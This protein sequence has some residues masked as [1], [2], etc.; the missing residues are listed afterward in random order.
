[1]FYLMTMQNTNILNLQIFQV[2]GKSMSVL[3]KWVETCL[4]GQGAESQQGMLLFPQWR[5]PCLAS[6]L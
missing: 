5:A 1:M 6:P 2:T 4:V 3:E